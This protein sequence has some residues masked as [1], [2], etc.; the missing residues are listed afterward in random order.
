M[1]QNKIVKNPIKYLHKVANGLS[2]IL[3]ELRQKL[4][5]KRKAHEQLA[6]NTNKKA[7]L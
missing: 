4:N 5:N 7:V 3:N 6:I 2:L 1:S